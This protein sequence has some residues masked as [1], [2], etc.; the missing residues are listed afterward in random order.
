MLGSES[1]GRGGRQLW[2]NPPPLSLGDTAQ[3]TQLKKRNIFVD[4][5]LTRTKPKL[6]IIFI[7]VV[8]IDPEKEKLVGGD[9]LRATG[10]LRVNIKDANLGGLRLNN[11]VS[12]RVTLFAASLISTKKVAVIA[13][14]DRRKRL[15]GDDIS[16]KPTIYLL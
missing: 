1:A 16:Q 13:N 3:L 12:S 11:N 6:V 14:I 4:N 15:G 8:L 7:F 5:H 10:H 2:K 9:R